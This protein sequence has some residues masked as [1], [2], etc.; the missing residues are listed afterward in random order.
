MYP[1]SPSIVAGSLFVTVVLA[2]PPKASANFKRQHA[3]SCIE[4]GL[5][6]TAMFQEQFLVNTSTTVA[7]QFVCAMPEDTDIRKDK[8]VTLNVTGI[9]QATAAQVTARACVGYAGATGGQC[10]PAIANGAASVTGAFTLAVPHGCWNL[11]HKLDYGY[12]QISVPQIQQSYSGLGGV[13]YAD[14]NG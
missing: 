13:Y 7:D 5:Q 1:R 2:S 6:R 11:S 8:V 4:D 3:S 10:D 9:D 14:I 12:V